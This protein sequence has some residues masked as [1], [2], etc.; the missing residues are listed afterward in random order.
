MG[1]FSNT[2]VTRSGLFNSK[3]DRWG[4]I[5]LEL[6]Y[7][8]PN[9]MQKYFTLSGAYRFYSENTRH[10]WLNLGDLHVPLAP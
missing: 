7:Q 2:R 4:R 9:M 10:I 3:V 6:A 5:S 8:V 1:K